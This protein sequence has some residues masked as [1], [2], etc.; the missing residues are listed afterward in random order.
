MLVENLFG[1]TSDAI[2]YN[3]SFN[4]R[5]H[6]FKCQCVVKCIKKMTFQESVSKLSRHFYRALKTTDKVNTTQTLQDGPLGA[7]TIFLYEFKFQ[8]LFR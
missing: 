3:A 1:R 5:V 6:V 8:E 4:V 7:A 2:L